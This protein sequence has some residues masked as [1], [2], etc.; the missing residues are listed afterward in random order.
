MSPG[1]R[2]QRYFRMIPVMPCAFNQAAT[3]S[4]SSSQNKLWYPPPGQ[5]SIAVPV[6]LSGAGGP[7]FHE[8]IRARGGRLVIRPSM[9]VQHL[10]HYAFLAF[11]VRRFHYGRCFGAVRVRRASLAMKVLYRAAAPAVAPVLIARHLWRAVSHPGNRQLLPGAAL[12][13]CGVCTFWGLGE[14]LGCWFGAGR[15]CQELY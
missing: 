8:R 6:F 2:G 14:W 13:L 10:T 5:I 4:P 7:F 15:S 1:R 9:C 3:S 12:A 11:G